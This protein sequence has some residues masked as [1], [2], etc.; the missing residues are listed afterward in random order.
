MA[1]KEPR[2]RPIVIGLFIHNGCILVGDCY[3]PIKD[4]KFYRPLGGAIEFGEY[5]EVALR[6]E[7]Q[8]EL[9]AEITDIRYLGMIENLFTF[10]GIPGHEIVLVYDATFADSSRYNQTSFIG[11]EGGTPF[12]AEWLPP[13]AF[14][15]ITPVYP[16][17]ILEFL[18]EKGILLTESGMLKAETIRA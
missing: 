8:E 4:Q 7:I 9:N 12:T 18:F 14:N 16:E 2:I 15:A 11:D 1:V 13:S 5:G 10:D 17:G 6:R 3:D